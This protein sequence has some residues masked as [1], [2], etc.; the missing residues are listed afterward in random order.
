MG[1]DDFGFLLRFLQLITFSSSLER[2][3][4]YLLNLILL[5]STYPS[6]SSP[7]STESLSSTFSSTSS[8]STPPLTT[9]NHFRKIKIANC[10]ILLP[11]VQLFEIDPSSTCPELIEC[12]EMITNLF[13]GPGEPDQKQI[14]TLIRKRLF[15]VFVLKKYDLP[16]DKSIAGL[17]V[18][19]SFGFKNV[20]HL[21][22][23]IIN[24]VY[25]GKGLGTIIMQSLISLLKAESQSLDNHPKYLTLECEERIMPFYAKTSFQDSELSP[26]PCH[27]EKT[28][29]K[30]I[31][32]YRWMEAQLTEEI[33]LL[34]EKL[35]SCI[36][37][38]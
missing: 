6:S 29:K 14:L 35:W 12:V 15:R 18:I 10:S 2:D 32:M 8:L 19:S 37:P 3:L 30:V 27:A 13:Q 25:Q 17:V 26:L 4:S 34:R 20:V 33:F 9:H 1:Q 36:E 38:N 22:Y 7:S 24:E 5:L 16:K 11:K 28:G 23:T 21:E 31:I